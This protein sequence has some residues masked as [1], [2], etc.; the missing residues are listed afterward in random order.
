MKNGR[1]PGVDGIPIKL[2]KE[3]GRTI[4]KYML[5][6]FNNIYRSGIILEEWR[7]TEIVPVFKKKGD[8]GMCKNYRAISLI[9]HITKYYERVEEGRLRAVLESMMDEVQHGYRRN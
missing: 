4:N 6:L 9:P 5:E 8:A 7:R 2:V 3:G 1:T